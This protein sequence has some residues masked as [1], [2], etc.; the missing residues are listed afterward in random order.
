M[1]DAYKAGVFA[2]ILAV[3]TMLATTLIDNR[4][5][6]QSCKELEKRLNINLSYSYN[7]GC[8]LPEDL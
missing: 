1:I 3:L 2:A 8:V 5:E 6:S 4:F 7:T